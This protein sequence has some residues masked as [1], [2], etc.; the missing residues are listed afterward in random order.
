MKMVGFILVSSWMVGRASHSFAS[1]AMRAIF[2][3]DES[4]SPAVRRLGVRLPSSTAALPSAFGGD[5]LGTRAIE[6]FINQVAGVAEHCQH[7]LDQ[8]HREDRWVQPRSTQ[9]ALLPHDAEWVIRNAAALDRVANAGLCMDG[10]V[11]P[12][13]TTAANGFARILGR[14]PLMRFA[15]SAVARENELM[16]WGQAA[17]PDAGQLCQMVN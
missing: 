1:G 15:E 8:R 16:R 11:G 2:L 10:A 14:N 9:T 7:R 3:S 5:Q 12:A 6:R 13:S 17:V 4:Y